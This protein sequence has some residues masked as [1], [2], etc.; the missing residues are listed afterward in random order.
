MSIIDKIRFDFSVAATSAEADE[1][2][3][4]VRNETSTT[5]LHVALR[6]PEA[7]IDVYPAEFALAPRSAQT[8]SVRLSPEKSR[9][10][11]APTAVKLF[12]QFLHVNA[13]ETGLVPP[14]IALE[15]SVIP[16]AANCPTCGTSLPEQARDC[17]RCGERIRLCPVCAAPNSW[18]A[19]NC[20]LNA[21]HIIRTEVDWLTSP[22]GD[23]VHGA[24]SNV[25][26]GPQLARK[27]SLPTFAPFCVVVFY[28][29]SAPLTAFGMLFASAIDMV[30]AR[31]FVQA[32]EIDTGAAL[33]DLE[34]P[35]PRGVY[36]DR[37]SMALST[38]GVLYVPT[39]GGYVTAIDAVRGT[40]KWSERFEGTVYG[41]AV[42]VDDVLLVP[43][44][45]T[46][47]WIDRHKGKEIRRVDLGARLDTAPCADSNAV[48]V[49]D[50]EGIVVAIGI[51]DGVERWRT[52]LDGAFD[53]APVLRDGT[54]YLATMS[55]T[56]YAL[57]ASTGAEKWQSRAT[58]KPIAV[59]PALSTDGLL[60]VSADDG[61][62]HIIAADTGNLVRTKKAAN[63]P[64][65]NSPVVGGNTAFLGADDGNIYSIDSDYGVHLAYETSAGSRIAGAGLAS[66]GSLVAFASTNG[67]LYVLEAKG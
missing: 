44:G 34:L 32:F 27:W 38:D 63:A 12:G 45:N 58:V 9:D 35:D 17:K 43:L 16:P 1:Q 10:A 42:V 53:A 6:S 33:W 62:L 66:Y 52:R 46:L 19:R 67:V 4:V 20:R 25:R 61:S 15:L 60:Y 55:G 50:D 31:S 21:S 54:L 48:Y 64:L 49:A 29:W 41:G 40:L 65:R 47:A 39:L 36:P 5:V 23:S 18:I 11:L 28:E 37:G 3:A 24:A 22:G 57:D 7:W 14:D 8:V 26:L 13:N 51:A 56:V 59:S 30:G 2:T